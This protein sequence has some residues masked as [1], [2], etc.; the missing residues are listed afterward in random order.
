[1]SLDSEIVI[2]RDLNKNILDGDQL[3]LIARRI[4]LVPQVKD[5]D[6]G[7]VVSGT[8]VDCMLPYFNIEIYKDEKKIRAV[9]RN[10]AILS[11]YWEGIDKILLENF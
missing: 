1:M 8:P 11:K 3:F 7:F 4:F 2:E 6:Y 5:T 10:E 9:I